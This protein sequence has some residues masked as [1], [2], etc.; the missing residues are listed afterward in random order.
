MNQDPNLDTSKMNTDPNTACKEQ[1][2]NSITV[3]IYQKICPKL[4]VSKKKCQLNC[5][6]TSDAIKL[7]VLKNKNSD[8]KATGIMRYQ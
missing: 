5:R 6:V 1:T 2:E 7:S 4:D 8:L 3:N